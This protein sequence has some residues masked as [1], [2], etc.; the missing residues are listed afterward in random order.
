MREKNPK[1]EP[2]RKKRNRDNS[3]I[4]KATKKDYFEKHEDNYINNG[5]FEKE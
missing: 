1:Y 5:D 4:P 2:K 3:L